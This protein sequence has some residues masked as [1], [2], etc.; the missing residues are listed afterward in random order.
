MFMLIQLWLTVVGLFALFYKLLFVVIKSY[1][2][3][4]LI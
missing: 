2:G 1:S 4:D 3:C